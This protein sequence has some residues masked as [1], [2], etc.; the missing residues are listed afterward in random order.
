MRRAYKTELDLNNEQVTMCLQHAGAAR[1]AYNWGLREIIQARAR[2]EKKPTA[3]DLHKKLNALKATEFPWMYE[4]S[5]CA[6][7]EALRNLDVAFDNFFRRCKQGVKKKGFPKFK[8]R[9][10]GIG[11]FRLTGT[12]RITDR[13][14]QLPRLGELRLKEDD[15]LPADAEISSATVSEKNGRWYVSVLTE[16][17]VAEC[18][19]PDMPIVGIDLGI[20]TLAVL[21]SGEV[22]ENPKHLRAAQRKLKRLQRAVSRRK[23]GSGRRKDAVR[24]LGK[25][26]ERVANKRKDAINKFTTKVTRETSVI[27]IEDLS[28]RG[29][30]ANHHLAGA[31]ADTSFGEIRRQIEY[32]AGWYGSTVVVIDRFAPTSKMCSGCGCIKDSLSLSERTFK[33]DACGLVIDRDLNAALN[34]KHLAAS[35]ADSLN[36]RGLGSTGDGRKSVVKLPKVKRQLNVKSDAGP[37]CLS[38]G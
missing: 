18:V 23:K 21:S 7:Q 3:I 4:S 10:A 28:V 35:Y 20:K 36:G 8:S 19:T 6:P 17:E 33:C 24:R 22:I 38:F 26:H 34:I 32:K 27:G 2:G 30:M 11:S 37:I 1:F 16:A 29:M 9:K 25:Q 14:I 13:T 15:Y 5:K 31:L 12:I